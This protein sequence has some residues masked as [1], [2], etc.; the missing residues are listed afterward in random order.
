MLSPLCFQGRWIKSQIVRKLMVRM[1]YVWPKPLSLQGE[2]ACWEF[3]P[4]WNG[5]KVCA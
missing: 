2:A 5:A 1:L 4:S 3:L